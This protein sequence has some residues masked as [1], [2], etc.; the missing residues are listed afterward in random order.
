MLS[1]AVDVTLTHAISKRAEKVTAAL[2][3][4]ALPHEGSS[5]TSSAPKDGC[6][7]FRD[8]ALGERRV[9]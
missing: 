3:S 6:G 8:I 9:H 7:Q 5:T 1:C 4:T 2:E